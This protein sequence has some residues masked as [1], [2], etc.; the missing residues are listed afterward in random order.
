MDIKKISATDRTILITGETGV[1]KTAYAKKIHFLSG[2]ENFVQLNIGSLTSSLF[3]SE[4]F[5]HVKGAFSGAINTKQGFC[6]SV[7]RGTLFIDEIGELNLELQVKLLTLIDEGIYYPVGSC[8]QKK[9][10]GRLIFATNK[11]LEELILKEKFRKDLFY[12]LRYFLLELAPIRQKNDIFKILMKSVQDLNLNN[13]GQ[14]LFLSTEVLERLTSYEWPGNYRELNNT[15]DYLNILGKERINLEDLPPW[16]SGK[17]SNSGK[18]ENISYYDAIEHFE[19][20]YFNKV[21]KL[22]EGKINLTAENI[23]LSKVT[24]ISKLKK[25]DIDRRVYKNFNIVDKAH[26]F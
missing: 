9:F 3:E 26:G 19:R 18:L 24:L 25:Y 21:L 4:L 11:N 20:D 1:G 13:G 10:K 6:E 7:G 15:M 12:R 5:G 14:N 2:R 16:I 8:E 22:F 23:G 17:I